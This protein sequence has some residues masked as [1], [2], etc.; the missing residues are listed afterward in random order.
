[1]QLGYP[2]L[3]IAIVVMPTALGLLETLE[4]VTSA[5]LSG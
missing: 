1:V 2:G 3:K 4:D 5:V